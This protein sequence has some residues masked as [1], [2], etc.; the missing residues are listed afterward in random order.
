M[1]S[2]NFLFKWSWTEL[3]EEIT[4]ILNKSCLHSKNRQMLGLCCIHHYPFHTLTISRG[5]NTKRCDILTIFS[6]EK[7]PRKTQSTFSLV[8]TRESGPQEWFLTWIRELHTRI[9]LGY[10]L[11]LYLQNIHPIGRWFSE[12]RFLTPKTNVR[13]IGIQQRPQSWTPF[14]SIV[15]LQ[16]LPWHY[17]HRINVRLLTLKVVRSLYK[18]PMQLSTTCTDKLTN[19]LPDSDT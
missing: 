5:H 19:Q 13:R 9:N 7:L 4:I 3:F 17:W 1:Y 2:L 16:W 18:I 8:V 6:S 15:D 12:N 10:F 14:L 11:P